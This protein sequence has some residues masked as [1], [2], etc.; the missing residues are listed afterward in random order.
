MKR[1]IERK[2]VSPRSLAIFFFRQLFSSNYVGT[3]IRWTLT[4]N[5]IN[6][7]NYWVFIK[8]FRIVLSLRIITIV[9]VITKPRRLYFIYLHN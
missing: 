7:K 4:E 3:F 2:L 1:S 9:K 5:Q 6:L 8:S